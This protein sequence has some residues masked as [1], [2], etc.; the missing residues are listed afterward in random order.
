MAS[1]H[2]TVHVVITDRNERLAEP[3]PP[4][5]VVPAAERDVVPGP[6]RKILGRPDLDAAVPRQRLRFEARILGVNMVDG[7]PQLRDRGEWIGAHPKQMAGVE[8]DADRLADRVAQPE[9]LKLYPLGPDARGWEKNTYPLFA[10]EPAFVVLVP[11]NQDG[12]S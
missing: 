8:I 3:A 5:F 1:E 11:M 9:G 6:V 4:D 7:R 2:R 10:R 12:R